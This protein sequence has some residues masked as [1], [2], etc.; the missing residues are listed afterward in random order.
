MKRF[1]FT[2][3]DSSSECVG[4]AW[5][6]ETTNLPLSLFTVTLLSPGTMNACT[7]PLSRP[8][9]SAD[10]DFSNLTIRVHSALLYFFIQMALSV[11]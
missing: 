9:S 2:K 4:L 8:E 1:I 7:L 5:V 11:P 6:S 10:E 3:I